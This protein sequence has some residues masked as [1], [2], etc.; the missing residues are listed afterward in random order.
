M[1]SV[2]V[3]LFVCNEI[4]CYLILK[5]RARNEGRQF[6]IHNK[7][8]ALSHILYMGLARVIRIGGLSGN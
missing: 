2:K 7:A 5:T 6:V 8:L 3:L 1:K 4:G